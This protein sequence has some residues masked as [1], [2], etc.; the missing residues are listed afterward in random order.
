MKFIILIKEPKTGRMWWEDYNNSIEDPRDWSIK[1]LAHFNNTLRPHEKKRD[2]KRIIIQD[3][4][5]HYEHYF[6]KTSLV[7][8]SGGFDKMKCNHCGIT[9]KRYGIGGGTTIDPKWKKNKKYINC[10]N[11]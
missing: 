2:F 11:K 1:T 9:G 10:I 5:H 6:T 8:E 7:T 4:T 3:T